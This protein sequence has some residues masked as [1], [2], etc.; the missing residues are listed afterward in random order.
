M[1]LDSYYPPA[2]PTGG[3]AVDQPA[4]DAAA[5]AQ[6]AANAA[7]VAADA[8]I[9][10][11]E[12]STAANG[13]L[14]AGLQ[15]PG[16]A[17][18]WLGA[19]GEV[20]TT[21]A[22]KLASAVEPI[23]FGSIGDGATHPIGAAP[24][25]L[26]ADIWALRA[27]L[28]TK[29]VNLAAAAVVS[30]APGA[31]AGTALLSFA[32][33]WARVTF[34]TTAGTLTITSQSA[35]AVF[36]AATGVLTGSSGTASKFNVSASGGLIY[37]NNRFAA[38]YALGWSD[39]AT[40]DETDWV[41]LQ[42]AINT[43]RK[44]RLGSAH[45]VINRPIAVGPDLAYAVASWYG[46]GIEGRGPGFP[47]AGAKVGEGSVIEYTGAAGS[48]L[49]V[50]IVGREVRLGVR[51]RGF[52]IFCTN[53]DGA[54]AGLRYSTAAFSGTLHEDLW[55]VNPTYAFEFVWDTTDASGQNGEWTK[56]HHVRCQGIVGLFKSNAGQALSLIFDNCHGYMRGALGEGDPARVA[57]F[58]FTGA[59]PGFELRLDNTAFT[60][61]DN[62]SYEKT[63][64]DF[65]GATAVGGYYSVTGGRFEKWST[66]V[67]H[68][69]NYG[70]RQVTVVYRDMECAG[71]QCAAAYPVIWLTT[72]GAG[73][74]LG[75]NF[76]ADHVVFSASSN[77][78]QA[79]FTDVSKGF[80]GSVVFDT[81]SFMGFKYISDK[82]QN[83]GGLLEYRN[84]LGV[85]DIA[86]GAVNTAAYPI[87]RSYGGIK[88]AEVRSRTW[89]GL[90]RQ[91]GELD[92]LLLNNKFQ[93]VSGVNQTPPTPWAV[94]GGGTTLT[95]IE[96]YP[97]DS[98]STGVAAPDGVIIQLGAAGAAGR[99]VEQT[100]STVALNAGAAGV[101][102]HYEALVRLWSPNS[103]L[104]FALVNS[105]D[106]TQIFDEAIVQSVDRSLVGVT[107]QR[108]LNIASGTARPKLIIENQAAT[109]L[110][111]SLL[112]QGFSTKNF[113]GLVDA[114]AAAAAG[115]GQEWH[116]VQ[117]LAAYGRLTLPTRSAAG[118]DFRKGELFF[119]GTNLRFHDGTTLRTVTVT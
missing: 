42:L 20:K 59:L 100:L 26:Y 38:T 47:I 62:A 103:P 102:L 112:A 119:D 91:D 40:S 80:A 92:N 28:T 33:E 94:R 7:L 109:G 60:C 39:V 22:T 117:R 30:F 88:T 31:A 52:T 67:K 107:L 16:S 37:L 84:C 45:Y 49:G 75:I 93:G 32:T 105:L 48:A 17:V 54:A 101:L 56:F 44:V 98:A 111:F 104:R 15:H 68:S 71:M 1:P 35:G 83:G 14:A 13:S 25:G 11:P 29:T 21:V 115:D 99:G 106:E 3:A 76:L 9:T 87:R 34:D 53:A 66:L 4:R 82:W 90:Q 51:F 18:A 10:E 19:P 5:A 63:I 2:P 64:F 108:R 50:I 116:T 89:G 43:K 72:G 65:S 74:A 97:T 58:S 12:L 57:L 96:Q 27:V 113:A 46:T 95:R 81:C 70:G 41:A 118:T 24:L 36:A 85:Q 110:F 61:N 86:D 69:D 8:G 79:F 23:Q 73:A 114:G 77:R 55:I 6:A 78:G